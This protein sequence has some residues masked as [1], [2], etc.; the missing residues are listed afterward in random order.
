MK[1]NL[2][3]GFTLLELLV[4]VAIIGL[5]TMVVVAAL[6][7]SRDKGGDAG[8]K[9]NLRNAIAQGEIFYGTNTA[10]P[11]SYTSVCTNGL[12]GGALGVGAQ[13][14]AAAKANGYS[15]GVSN[16]NPATV[17]ISK[18]ACN[19]NANGWAA[20]VPLKET[21]GYVWCVDWTGKSIRTTT[22]LSGGTDVL[23]N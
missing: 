17:D 23:C 4:V 19:F 1:T 15:Y 10:S 11:N 3:K 6:K 18:V 9:A 7:S 16:I 14:L 12:V 21:S 22:S 8:V 2:K 20:Q 5:L 13:I